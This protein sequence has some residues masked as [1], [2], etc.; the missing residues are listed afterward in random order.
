MPEIPAF[1]AARAEAWFGRACTVLETETLAPRLRRVRFGGAP[2]KRCGWRPGHEVEVRV[3]AREFRHYTPMRWDDARG[4]VDILFYLHGRGP[5]SAW[6]EALREGD[7]THLMGPGGRLRLD[8]DAAHHVFLGDETTAGLFAALARAVP[9]S[10]GLTGA[11]EGEGLPPDLF[12]AM[13]LPLDVLSRGPTRGAALL[14]W[15]DRV[16]TVDSVYYLAG[17]AESVVALRRAL[18]R[19]WSIPARRI[20]TKAYWSDNRRGL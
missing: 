20:R 1:L 7:A 6:A 12:T 2:L 17:H 18:Q 13:G 14:A 4:E 5:G 10:A 11:V 16:V 19:Q 15:L 3:G 8:A 9:P